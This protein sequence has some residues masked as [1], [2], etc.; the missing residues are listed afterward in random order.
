MEQKYCQSCGM[1]MGDADEMYGTNQDGTKNEDYC[2]Y[3]YA[4]GKFT[5]E[6]TMDEMIEGCIQYY[7]QDK[8]GATE[9]E[10]RKMMKEFFPKLK[11]WQV[12]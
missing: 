8:P 12:A 7:I 5:S 10:A 1:P 11:R 3:C 6:M 2:I 9:E 4:D